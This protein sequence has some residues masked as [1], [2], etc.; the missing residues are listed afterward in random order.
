MPGDSLSDDGTPTKNIH[1]AVWIFLIVCVAATI[2]I[3]TLL[4]KPPT[5][6]CDEPSIDTSKW[7]TGSLGRPIPNV[8]DR[9]S[10]FK[11]A[12]PPLQTSDYIVGVFKNHQFYELS[13]ADV[14]GCDISIKCTYKAPDSVVWH[15]DENLLSSNSIQYM[16]ASKQ[17]MF[18]GTLPENKSSNSPTILTLYECTSGADLAV[19]DS[20]I[21]QIRNVSGHV[22]DFT[23][24]IHDENINISGLIFGRSLDSDENTCIYFNYDDSSLNTK[25][26]AIVM[27]PTFSPPDSA[28]C[29]V[30][31]SGSGDF[32]SLGKIDYQTPYIYYVVT[33]D[34]TSVTCIKAPDFTDI[35]QDSNYSA[36]VID[37]APLRSITPLISTPPQAL[38]VY[39]AT[40]GV[41][42]SCILTAKSD[43][44]DRMQMESTL[45][46]FIPNKEV[47][48][49]HTF[50]RIQDGII[51]LY[52]LYSLTSSLYVVQYNFNMKLRTWSQRTNNSV[53]VGDPGTAQFNI[54]AIAD[55]WGTSG[56]A[57]CIQNDSYH[58][59][60]VTSS[61]GTYV[62][63]EGFDG[64]SDQWTTI[65]EG[66]RLIFP[67]ND[68]TRLSAL[69]IIED[70][71]EKVLRV[72]RTDELTYFVLGK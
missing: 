65:T 21:F 62:G 40:G 67:I 36:S 69:E 71:G 60:L 37:I 18:A 9:L 4:L 48:K 70:N 19:V 2:C 46:I 22:V 63:C 29:R 27:E 12:L 3:V 35:D 64:N 6:C 14:D 32:V 54:M 38:V 43:G 16:N 45:K 34:D 11:I 61:N 28:C 57:I 39:I 44:N 33:E 26:S 7:Y 72:T 25:W 30:F 42:K 51:P 53:I 58:T 8:T 49:A 13:A 52:V 15:S 56:D 10:T 17:L 50:G 41:L 47:I 59:T 23:N 31:G 55:P 68:E 24:G 66:K 20:N 1:T 5:P